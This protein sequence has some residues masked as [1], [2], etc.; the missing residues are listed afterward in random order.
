[1]QLLTS[2]SSGSLEAFRLL[3]RTRHSSVTASE[4]SPAAMRGAV[5]ARVLAKRVKF[6]ALQACRMC[7]AATPGIDPWRHE[8]LIPWVCVVS[9]LEGQ[10]RATGAS[11][12]RWPT[13]A[14]QQNRSK[15]SKTRRAVHDRS[16]ARG[17]LPFFQMRLLGGRRHTKPASSVS[18]PFG[19]IAHLKSPWR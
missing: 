2:H 19:P 5:S 18:S 13:F 12:S 4:R 9:V 6:Q 8:E 11:E 1:M 14:S 16:S 17:R 10:S 7:C 15:V 3:Q